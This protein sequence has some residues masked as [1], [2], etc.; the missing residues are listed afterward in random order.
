MNGTI[1]KS[2]NYESIDSGKNLNR[3]SKVSHSPINYEQKRT[4]RV[5]KDSIDSSCNHKVTEEELQIS[6][7]PRSRKPSSAK[8]VM[9]GGD[10]Q[11]PKNR[12]SKLNKQDYYEIKN[13]PQRNAPSKNIQLP[14]SS[15]YNYLR[16]EQKDVLELYKRH[17][18]PRTRNDPQNGVNNYNTQNKVI[19]T[20]QR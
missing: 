15:K 1:K 14:K 6:I 17:Q 20:Q 16:T 10:N 19:N 9:H 18:S 2:T 7:L 11:K 13:S 12:Q 3:K 5:I 4:V 8:I